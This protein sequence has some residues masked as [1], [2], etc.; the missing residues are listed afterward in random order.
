MQTEHSLNVE[1]IPR[2][3]DPEGKVYRMTR[4]QFVDTV[5]STFNENSNI[6]SV[7]FG[8]L[9]DRG[10]DVVYPDGQVVNM[11]RTKEVWMVETEESI[12]PVGNPLGHAFD[13]PIVGTNRYFF[14]AFTGTFVFAYNTFL[15][16]MLGPE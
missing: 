2:G 16:E 14:L 4:E 9:I 5:V 15:K 3:S 11:G 8:V 13:P 1:F 6:L 7:Q 10:Q 12:S